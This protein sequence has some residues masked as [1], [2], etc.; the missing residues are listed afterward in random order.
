MEGRVG[1]LG[2]EKEEVREDVEAVA[3]WEGAMM[4]LKWFRDI[5][6]SA[7]MLR[8]LVIRVVMD[9][10]LFYSTIKVLG[11]EKLG[12]PKFMINQ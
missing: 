6:I 12:Y 11:R 2:G 7:S 1:A 5:I 3:R 8:A 4:E 9:K 10:I